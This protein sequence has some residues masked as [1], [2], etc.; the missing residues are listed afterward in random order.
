[1]TALVECT[2]EGVGR[3]VDLVQA[4][5]RAADFPVVVATG[6]YREPWVP[7]WA[8]ASSE[9][10]LCA[11]MRRELADGIAKTGVRA[12]FIKVSAGDDGLTPTEAK[13]LRAAGRAALAEGAAIGSHTIR[14][15]VARDQL[16]VLDSVGFPAQRFIWIHAHVEADFALNLELA[17][18]GAWIEYDGIG[19]EDNDELFI[20]RVQRMLDAGL[21]NRVMLSMDRGWYDPAQPGGGKPKPFTYLCET[22]LPRLRSAG[23][24]DLTIRQLTVDNPFHAFAR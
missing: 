2:P 5:S 22:F 13:I 12:G 20:G 24:E 23:V 6:I 1:V 8:R 11:W 21:G 16:D 19:W 3:R 4:V 10:D 17:R 14:G 7:D 18:R 15:R 9:D